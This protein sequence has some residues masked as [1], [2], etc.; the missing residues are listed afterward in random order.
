[1]ADIMEKNIGI[2]GCPFFTVQKLLAGKWALVILYFLSEETLRFNELQR[3]LDN[4]THATL[5]KQ[6]KSLEQSGLI[7]RKEYAQIPPKVE[8]S[9]SELGRKLQPSLNSLFEWGGEYMEYTSGKQM[10]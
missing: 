5:A 9:L 3:K 4:L 7:I 8:Y 2:Q 6:L 1:M 10:N